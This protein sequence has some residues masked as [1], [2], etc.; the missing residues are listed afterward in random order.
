VTQLCQAT[1]LWLLAA[2]AVEAVT[3]IVV[4][5]ELF[6]GLRTGISRISG[7]IGAFF[8]ALISCGY[9]F[10]VWASAAVAWA[11][12]GA[13]FPGEYG[14]IADIALR[15]FALHR[16]SNFVHGKIKVATDRPPQEHV[17]TIFLRQEKVDGK[18][19]GTKARAGNSQEPS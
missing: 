18:D 4:S 14:W 5:S 10:S 19:Q 15:T 7:R 9:C 16:V 6:F 3:E 8:G 17:L 2:L 11:L 12:P 1:L 13:L